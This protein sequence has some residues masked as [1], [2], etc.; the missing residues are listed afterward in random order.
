MTAK[1][2]VCP[3][4]KVSGENAGSQLITTIVSAPYTNYTPFV[5]LVATKIISAKSGAVTV[6][7]A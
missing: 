2:K 4:M 1:D 3:V 5:I 7:G 6:L